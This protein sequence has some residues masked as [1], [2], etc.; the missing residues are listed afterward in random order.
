MKFLLLF[1]FILNRFRKSIE[2]YVKDICLK[3]KNFTLEPLFADIP[4]S[5]ETKKLLHSTSSGLE[6][7]FLPRLTSQGCSGAYYMHDSFGQKVAV[8]KPRD[9]EP[10]AVNNPRGKTVASNH[11]CLKRGVK[12][13]DGAIREVAAYILDHPRRINDENGFAGVPQTMMVKC[14]QKGFDSLESLA[15]EKI[16]SLQRYVNNKGSSDEFGYGSFPRQEVHKISVLDIRLAN[17]DRHTGNILVATDD[18][19]ENKLIPIDH[20]YCLPDNA[21][22]RF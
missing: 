14:C 4:L 5:L 6:R 9:E 2:K 3:A 13:G 16:G 19:G 17:G 12:A 20:G 1:V 11:K 21:I 8:F 18:N 15:N 10:M 7:G 22:V